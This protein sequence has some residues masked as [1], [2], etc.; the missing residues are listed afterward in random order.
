MNERNFFAELKQRN[1][2]R[3]ARL[4]LVGAWLLIQVASTV[5][6]AFEEAARAKVAAKSPSRL[7]EASWH[8]ALGFARAG[9][10]DAAA[11]VSEGKAAV[12]L[13]PSEVDAWEGP[14]FEVWL[15]EIYALN[16]DAD[17]ALALLGHAQKNVSRATAGASLKF[18]PVWDPIRK[19]ARFQELLAKNP[20]GK[21]RTTGR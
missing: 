5:L 17:H 6:P 20:I 7:V 15:A 9:L 11:A 14:D 18:D 21:K 8:S 13:I 1:V 3:V 4:Y 12:A 16:G 10:G 19:D 2:I